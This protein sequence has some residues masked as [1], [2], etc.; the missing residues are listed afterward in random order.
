M[1][2]GASYVRD[3]DLLEITFRRPERRNAL[4]A[5]E[6]SVLEAAITEAENDGACEFVILRGEGRV[7]CSGVDLS[8]IEKKSKEDGGLLGLIE[9][10]GRTLQRLELLP[11]IVIVALNGPALG[12]GMHIALCADV[13]LA[14]REAYLCIPEAKLGIPD[15]LHF[16][17][18]EQRLGR[19][20]AIE[21]VL[22]GEKLTAEDAMGR[23]LIGRVCDNLDHGIADHLTRLRSLGSAVRRAVKAYARD[24]RSDAP[25]QLAASASVL[26]VTKTKTQPNG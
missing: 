11:Q 16:K 3:G 12:I 23:G 8:W 18:I 15:V 21:M 19:S 2:P 25:G 7:F 4:G 9:A 1:T 20:A 17:L 24:G 26:G 5:A 13:V 10:N 6:W 14:T 22:L